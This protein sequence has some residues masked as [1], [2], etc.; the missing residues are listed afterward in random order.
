[1]PLS[2]PC[3]V[4]WNLSLGSEL[5]TNV[6]L[7]LRPSGLLQQKT[8]VGVG[9]A[10]ELQESTPRSSGGRLQAADFWWV[11]WQEEGHPILDESPS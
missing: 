9:G 6:G 11:M 7:C 5:G 1:M 3:A 4:A 8:T 10:Y 2:P